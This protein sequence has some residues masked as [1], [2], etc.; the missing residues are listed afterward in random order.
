[1]AIQRI[2]GLPVTGAALFGGL[3]LA[4]ASRALGLGPLLP[5]TSLV[6]PGTIPAPYAYFGFETYD[7]PWWYSDTGAG[8]ITSYDSEANYPWE[9]VTLGGFYGK[10]VEDPYGFHLQTLSGLLA[11]RSSLAISCWLAPG[12]DLY[13]RP[14]GGG[15]FLFHVVNDGSV[16]GHWLELLTADSIMVWRD[17]VLQPDALVYFSQAQTVDIHFGE[18]GGRL[19]EFAFW[20]SPDWTEEQAAAIAAAL[21]NDGLGTVYRDG[22]WWEIA[23]L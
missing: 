20:E 5:A 21:Y 11:G 14:G 8:A 10:C 15:S 9:W 2:G 22:Q 16:W 13:I 3:P 17:G 1:M 7:P 19:D 18:G 23:D 4:G 6:A 12:A